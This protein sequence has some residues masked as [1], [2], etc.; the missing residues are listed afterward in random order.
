MVSLKTTNSYLQ[1]KMQTI[2][3]KVD[4]I[5]QIAKIKKLKYIDIGLEIRRNALTCINCAHRFALM[6]HA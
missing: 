1:H 2:L 6:A 3:L 5:I 4:C